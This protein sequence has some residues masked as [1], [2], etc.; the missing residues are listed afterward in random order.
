MINGDDGDG[1]DGGSDVDNNEQTHIPQQ[2]SKSANI[3]KSSW[4][5][6]LLDEL[7]VYIWRQITYWIL[8]KTPWYVSYKVCPGFAFNGNSNG[9]SVVPIEKEEKEKEGKGRKK[10][11]RMKKE[12]STNQYTHRML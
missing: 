10:K 3:Y 2:I 1:D 12:N 9:I 7:H 6:D 11:M 4:I 8:T 5:F